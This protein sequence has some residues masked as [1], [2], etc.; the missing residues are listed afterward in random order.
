MVSQG[1][2]E[3]DENI[4]AIQWVNAECSNEIVAGTILSWNERISS[5]VRSG[6]FLD[7][8]SMGVDFYENGLTRAA[9]GLPADIDAKQRIVGDYLSEMV[10]SYVNMSLSG[11]E[12]SPTTSD[13]ST[14]ELVLYRE[15]ANKAIETC[16]TIQRPDI[17][18]GEIFD[19]FADTDL[20]GQFLEQLEPYILQGR[21]LQMT[22]PNVVQ[23]FIQHYIRRGWFERLEEVIMHLDPSSLDIN[24]IVN[25]ARQHHLYSAMIFVY[26]RALRDYI[27]PIVELLKVVEACVPVADAKSPS[28]PLSIR[29][30][31]NAAPKEPVPPSLDQD[32]AAYK[33]Y[34][35]LAYILTGK[36]FPSGMIE[37]SEALR[38]KTD[39][40]N[41]LFSPYYAFWPPE[42]DEAD[43][44]K[45]GT[46]PFPYVRLLLQYDT[47]EFLKVMGMAFEDVSLNG[48]IPM[49]D[50]FGTN[51]QISFSSFSEIN[52]QFITDTL[53]TV[54]EG[55]HPPFP[56]KDLRSLY[57]F[58]ARNYSKYTT[59]L[60]LEGETLR[61]IVLALVSEQDEESR[62]E[63]EISVLALLDVYNP[64][65]TP[66]Q[67]DEF[68]D[69]CEK[70]GL[71]RVC[72][73][74]YRKDGKYE[75]ILSCY[76][77]DRYRQS[78]V[79]SCIRELLGSQ[80]L[81]FE[82]TFKVKQSVFGSLMELVQLDGEK[83]ADV[84]SDFFPN[85]HHNVLKRLA[86]HPRIQYGYLK[87]LLRPS[88]T[89]SSIPSMTAAGRLGPSHLTSDLYE[90]LINLMCDFEPNFVCGFL[91]K[92]DESLDTYP[93]SVET[94]LEM[95]KTRR[96]T[97][98]AVWLLE[99]SG[100]FPGALG[101]VCDD[102]LSM[103]KSCVQSEGIENGVDDHKLPLPT[104]SAVV[105]KTQ[106]A[107]QVCRRASEKLKGADVEPLWLELLDCILVTQ[108]MILESCGD[109]SGFQDLTP[110]RPTAAATVTSPRFLRELSLLVVT[111]MVSHV[112]LP[113]IL[114][115]MLER[116]PHMRF[117]DYREIIQSMLSDSAYERQLVVATN[118]IIAQDVYKFKRKSVRL[119]LGALRPGKGQCG[120]CGRLL[121]VRAMNGPDELK[122]EIVVMRCQHAFHF[123]CLDASFLR[124][125][126]GSTACPICSKTLTRSSSM[127]DIATSFAAKGKQRA[128]TVEPAKQNESTTGKE[129]APLDRLDEYSS[130]SQA[131]AWKKFFD[132]LSKDPSREDEIHLNEADEE[133]SEDLL[134]GMALV[135]GSIGNTRY[136][137]QLAPPT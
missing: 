21:V 52:R 41:F 61:K 57:G 2:Y 33:L 78:E 26:N 116:Q 14:E 87:G 130:V 81:N 135:D 95:C 37:R 69:L 109:R 131:K 136:H 128:Q 102:I 110:V 22:Y 101:L 9:I 39:V 113:R 67:S 45:I 79:F 1:R 32:A 27:T 34:V 133:E 122:S 48:E 73:Q 97:D 93:Y 10:R 40:Y 66:V 88:S 83:A 94:V 86:T 64:A 29:N 84:V 126:P 80:H 111:S 125:D 59:F 70:S 77:N 38:A 4:V 114:K 43:L 6:N 65:R 117:K 49:Q 25:S 119:R 118:R 85:D 137:L 24:Q 62:Q 100:D 28:S 106:D 120:V 82:E 74:S 46:A 63:R 71:W 121:H 107:I 8:I 68:L 12:A 20:V 17:L 115:R 18:F 103:A 96:L 31:P 98:A 44:L 112:Q 53:L 99:R 54:F 124:S 5:L 58:V 72:E 89:S 91:Q 105:A 11:Y 92:L 134:H 36:A 50:I 7:A 42:D 127:T 123:K 90:M 104:P 51:N 19:R 13:T 129:K 35:Y 30:T 76:L 132:T 56:Q 16:L 75:K 23:S 3:F 15:V 60:A 47:Q 108:N 55:A